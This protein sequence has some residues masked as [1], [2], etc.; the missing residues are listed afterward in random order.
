MYIFLEYASNGDLFEYLR[1]NKP[2]KKILLNFFYQTLLSINYLHERNI[3]HRDLKPENI[4]IDSDFNIKICD[5]GWS[6]RVKENEER[7][8]LCGTYEYMA[9]EVY[10][11]YS[12]TKKTDIW[13]LG[14]LLF[15]L[16][17]G[18]PPLKIQDLDQR[19]EGNQEF[20]IMF[21]SELD[22]RIK[23]LV[24]KILK[25]KPES[26]PVINEILNDT[27]FDQFRFK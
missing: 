14:I 25:M 27:L 10:Q 5:F 21:K 12:Q 9:P 19:I 3:M 1:K 17:H 11:G 20:Y 24:S 26:R 2:E 15:E 23:R 18:Y 16:F 8:T 22:V 6:V 13:A 7:T 4:L